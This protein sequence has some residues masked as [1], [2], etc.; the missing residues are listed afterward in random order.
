MNLKRGRNLTGV[1]RVDLESKPKKGAVGFG[2]GDGD[3]TEA[4][5]EMSF[6]VYKD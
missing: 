4:K 1:Q 2:D 3:G 5:F 6:L